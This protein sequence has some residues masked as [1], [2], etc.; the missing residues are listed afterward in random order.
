MGWGTVEQDVHAM[1]TRNKEKERAPVIRLLSPS[2]L[3]YESIKGLIH[4]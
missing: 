2:P 1:V 3:I 4:F